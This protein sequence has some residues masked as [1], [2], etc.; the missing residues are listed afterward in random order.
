VRLQDVFLQ[1]W[2][3]HAGLGAAAAAGSSVGFGAWVL[4][5]L[6]GGLPQDVN[7]RVYFRAYMLVPLQGAELGAGAA[8]GTLGFHAE[9]TLAFF[10]ATK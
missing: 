3:L 8:A 9:T 10:D 5:P 4:V 6:Q 2:S 7:G 1:C